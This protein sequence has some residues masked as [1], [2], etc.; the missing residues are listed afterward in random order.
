ME[1]FTYEGKKLNIIKKDDDYGS[2]LK[3]LLTSWEYTRYSSKAIRE[4]C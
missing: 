3:Q 1:I 4:T 2:V